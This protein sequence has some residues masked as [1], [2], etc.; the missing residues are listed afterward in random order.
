MIEVD[1][2]GLTQSEAKT[3]IMQ[4]LNSTDKNVY[5][6][7]IIHGY[8]HGTALRNM[9]R[10]NFRKHPKVERI[11]FGLNQGVTELILKGGLK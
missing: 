2:H 5:M 6:I 4:I 10:R 11:E 9:I 8:H 7:R 3:R 1:V